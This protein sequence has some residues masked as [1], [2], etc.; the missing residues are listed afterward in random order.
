MLKPRTAPPEVGA[1][2]RERSG[3]AFGHATAVRVN[4]VHPASQ[5]RVQRALKRG[6]VFMPQA[7]APN[8]AV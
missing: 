2:E 3:K 8:G 5:P 1:A 7:I 4:R 6:A